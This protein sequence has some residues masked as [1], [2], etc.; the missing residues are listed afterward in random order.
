MNQ[1]IPEAGYRTP[2]HVWLACLDRIGQ[3]LTRF[4]QRLQ[5]ANDCVLNQSGGAK[6]CF[7]TGN[8][9]VDSTRALQHVGKLDRVGLRARLH[10]AAITTS[11]LR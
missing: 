9:V 2:R 5:I 11:A 10:S 4:R 6:T 8:V 3:T 7:V 1:D